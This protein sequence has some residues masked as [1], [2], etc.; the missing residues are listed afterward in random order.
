MRNKVLL[1]DD[2]PFVLRLAQR[3]LSSLGFRDI[4][5]AHTPAEALAI[6]QR[7]KEEI[8][9]LLTDFNMPGMSGDELAAELLQSDPDL[10]IS[11]MSGNPPDFLDSKI[12]LIPGQNFVQKPFTAQKLGQVLRLPEL[13]TSSP[14]E[15]RSSAFNEKPYD[16]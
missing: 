3:L 4:I 8:G 13:A 15:H 10:E 14:S 6:W 16:I 1:V 5:I 9:I 2:D 7:R 12:P 11:F